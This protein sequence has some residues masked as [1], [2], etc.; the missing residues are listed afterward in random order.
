MPLSDHDVERV[1][2]AVLEKQKAYVIEDKEHY[3]AHQRI[4]RLL[5][6][7]DAAQNVAWKTFISLLVVGGI[8]V[9]AIAAGVGKLF[10]GG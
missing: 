10:K 9:A 8:L 1:A 3:D 6:M 2:E 4:D 7:Y 5:D